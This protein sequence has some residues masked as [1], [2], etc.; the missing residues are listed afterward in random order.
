MRSTL[1]VA[2]SAFAFAAC[3]SVV[4]QEC[5]TDSYELGVRDARRALPP[6]A[7]THVAQCKALGVDIDAARY[8]EGWRSAYRFH[9]TG[10]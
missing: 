5:R 6:Q 7:E 9:P 4:E 8:L 10:A 3:A 1:A 2:C